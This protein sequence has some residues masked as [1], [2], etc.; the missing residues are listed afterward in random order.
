MSASHPSLEASSSDNPEIRNA[1]A[2]LARAM[3]SKGVDKIQFDITI[4]DQHPT[5][6][7]QVAVLLEERVLEDNEHPLE[8]GLQGVFV[9]FSDAGSH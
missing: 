2:A 8:A 7:T 1:A 3:R 4:P 6:V 5:Q 9:V